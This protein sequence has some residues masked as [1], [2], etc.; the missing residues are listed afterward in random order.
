MNYK[1]S[2]TDVTEANLIE[3]SRKLAIENFAHDEYIFRQDEEGMKFYIILSGVVV[4]LIEASKFYHQGGGANFT[5]KEVCRLNEGTSFGE[6]ALISGASRSL[7]MRAYNSVTLIS[8]HKDDFLKCFGVVW[9]KIGQNHR[10]D[11]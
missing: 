9:I 11:N 6:L 10:K 5:D 4:G 1:E 7:S 3:I 2:D 8:L